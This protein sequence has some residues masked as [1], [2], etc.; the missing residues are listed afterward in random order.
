MRRGERRRRAVLR[1]VAAPRSRRASGRGLEVRK[2]VTVLFCDVVG[3]TSLGEATDPETTRRV[4]SRYA[5]SMTEIVTAHGGTVER[6]RGDEVMAVFGVP[7][8]HEDDA[9]RAVRAGMEMQRRLAELNVELQATW[10]VELACRIGINTG[11]VVAGDPGTGD[12][13]VTG[14][15]V[16]LAK[17]LEQAAQPGEILIGTATYP[18]VK[19]A[20]RGRAAGAVH[21]P[22]GSASRRPLPA[23]RR[24]RDGRGL[25][26]PPRRAARRPG[27]RARRASRPPS[28]RS[29]SRAAAASSASPARPGSASRGSSARSSGDSSDDATVAH[30]PMPPVRRRHHVLAAR[31]ARPRPRRARRCRDRPRPDRS[32]P[33]TSSRAFARSSPSPTGS[34]PNDEVFWAVRRL[35]EALALSATAPRVLRGPALGRADD[36]RPR[37]VPRA[38]AAGPIVL[39]LRRA[40]GAARGAAELGAL[41]ALRARS[42]SSDAETHELVG[43]LGVEDPAVRDR[44]ASTA[45][46]N[47]LFAEQLAVMIGSRTSGRPTSSSSPPRSRRCSRP[48]STG[49]SPVERR[50]ARTRLGRRQGVLAPR[51]RRPLARRGPAADRRFAALRSCG[52]ASSGRS[53]PTCRARTR[54]RFRHCADPRRRVRRAS[55]RRCAPSIHERFAAGSRRNAR[56][57]ASAST[58]RSSATTS[59]RRTAT[60]PSSAST[61][62]RTSALAARRGRICSARRAAG[63]RARRHAGG[64]RSARA[65]RRVAPG[66]SPATA[67]GP[68]RPGTRAVGGGARGRGHTRRSSVS[69]RGSCRRRRAR[70]EALRR[71]RAGRPRSAHGRGRR[72]RRGGGRARHRLELGHGDD[73]DARPGLASALV[74]AATCRRLRGRRGARPGGARARATRAGSRREEARAV[75]RRSATACSTARRRSREALSDVHGAARRGSRPTP[76][77]RGNVPGRDVAGLGRWSATST[78]RGARTARP[79]RCSR[80]SASSSPERR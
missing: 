53:A 29:S 14:D 49:S 75:R 10:G 23:R 20:V 19:D 6:F 70:S 62:A 52:R 12:T 43:S 22:R 73:V 42:T 65:D 47:P 17:R 5:Q 11:E 13:F 18:L 16:N 48:G 77:V 69:R 31:R 64:G 68:P 38:F 37:R 50:A 46:G 55:R 60:A 8:V 3:S 9:L 57:A 66:G 72:A 15:A 54:M 80:S 32:T 41:P 78:R 7:V 44:I 33:R 21:A 76:D 40:A 35:L 71:A 26:A 67:R 28:T 24:R 39:R 4:M 61:D 58:T 74:G 56:S 25:R 36:A 2:T 1:S 27:G 34:T 51:D 59:S 79:L 45:E 30:R 63:A